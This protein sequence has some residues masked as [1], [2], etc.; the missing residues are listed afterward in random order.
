MDRFEKI[1]KGLEWCIKATEAEKCVFALTGCPYVED[2]KV[3][4]MY[5]LKRD[6]L[7]LIQEQQKRIKELDNEP[8]R[9]IERYHNDYRCRN[10]GREVTR[11]DL[12][13]SHCGKRQKWI[14]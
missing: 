5:V 4:G 13:C 1:T 6:A 12:Y 10:C 14:K 3:E 11:Y 8:L 2:C 7:D 9:P